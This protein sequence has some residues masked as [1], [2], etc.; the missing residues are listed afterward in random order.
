MALIIKRAKGKSAARGRRHLRV[1]KKLSGTPRVPAWS[2]PG[3][4]RH[5][6]VQVVDDTAGRTA[7][8]GLHDG[9]GPALV[10]R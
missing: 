4:R 7:G 6:F 2:C 8:L 3:P 10:R 1:R 5:V 9:G